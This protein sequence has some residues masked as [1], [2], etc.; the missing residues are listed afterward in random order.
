MA[1][2]TT[3]TSSSTDHRA[4]SLDEVRET[5][6]EQADQ[7]D[8]FR[9]LNHLFTG[10]YRQR[11]FGR[12]EGRVLD[13]AC[14]TGLNARYLPASTTYVGID[15]SP[16]ML[17][18]ARHRVGAW[19]RVEGLHEMDAQALEFPDD[20]FD[21]VVSSLSTCTFPDPVAALDEMARV[22][23]PDGRVLLLEHGRSS[24]GPLARFQD[25]RADAHYENHSCR[26]NQEPLALLENSDL[27]VQSA[28]TALL[29]VITAIEAA[30]SR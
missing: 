21:T 2:T 20:S 19:D 18:K 26:W 13:V 25:W 15:A 8:R 5:Y 10:R 27:E 9:W 30:P 12:A 14:G 29:G 23:E 24:V 22:C 1:D 16:E 3:D 4:H 17:E 11:L 6:A 28:S 7:M